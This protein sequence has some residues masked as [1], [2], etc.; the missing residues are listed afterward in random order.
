MN[1]VSSAFSGAR[2]MFYD[3]TEFINWLFSPPPIRKFNTSTLSSSSF[4]PILLQHLFL[5]LKRLAPTHILINHDT[6]G[7]TLY[8]SWYVVPHSFSRVG[9][10]TNWFCSKLLILFGIDDTFGVSYSR[11]KRSRIFPVSSFANY[12][13]ATCLSVVISI[14]RQHLISQKLASTSWYKATHYRASP[15]SC[16]HTDHWFYRQ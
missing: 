16:G 8:L 12:L 10:R 9:F 5:L 1:K 6:T 4:F 3:Q 13:F 14:L 11:Q 2:S 15:F 7:P